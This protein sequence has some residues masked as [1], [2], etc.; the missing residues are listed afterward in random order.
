MLATKGSEMHPFGVRPRNELAVYAS[1]VEQSRTVE[2]GYFLGVFYFAL[3]SL[4]VI[5]KEIS[6]TTV[7]LF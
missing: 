3:C 1:E 2:Y 4:H 5:A 6:F 7:R